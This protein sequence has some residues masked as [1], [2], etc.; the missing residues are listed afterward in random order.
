MPAA[1]SVAVVILYFLS[2]FS[3]DH[4]C[5][6]TFTKNA[7]Q[8]ASQSTTQSVTQSSTQSVSQNKNTTQSVT[9]SASETPTGTSSVTG[10]PSATGTPVA[11]VGGKNPKRGLAFAAETAGDILNVNQTASV[12]SWQYDWANLPPP[13]LAT[14]NIKYIPMQWG[15]GSI[16]RFVDAVRAQ[17]ADTIL[18]FNEPDFANEA[19]MDPTEAARLW[20]T[21]I[22]PLKQYGHVDKAFDA[23]RLWRYGM[24]TSGFYDYLWTIRNEYPRL[25]VWVTE[26]ADTSDNATE[27]LNFMNETM[28]YMDGIE[29][30]ERY[31]WFGLFRPKAGVHYNMLREDGGLNALGELYT[32]AKTVH[33]E[34]IKNAALEGVYSR[35][36]SQFDRMGLL[37]D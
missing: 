27:V 24:G 10:I 4:C 21:Y 19:N 7:T 6:A 12:I 20:M 35:K 5:V 30:I 34:F 22:E 14:S 2:V 8:S 23:E 33:T 1:V 37:R 29:W 17:G 25:P 16:D 3:F 15:S 36:W 11:L 32:G 31:A 28:R 18:A 26:Y 9:Q 13:Y